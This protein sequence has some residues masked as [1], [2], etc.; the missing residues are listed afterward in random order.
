[1]EYNVNRS[2]NSQ[3]WI[4]WLL[5]HFNDEHLLNKKS[6]FICKC[7]NENKLLMKSAEKGQI[8][9]YLYCCIIFSFRNQI[10]VFRFLKKLRKRYL[11]IYLSIYMYVYIYIY[12]LTLYVCMSFLKMSNLKIKQKDIHKI[13]VIFPL[14]TNLL[15]TNLKKKHKIIYVIRIVIK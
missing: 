7:S 3:R 15:R 9:L 13:L 1:M 5:K 4:F 12:I 11:S 8:Y 2:W 10:F 6:E 14:F